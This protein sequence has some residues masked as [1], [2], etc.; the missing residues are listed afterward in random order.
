MPM[1]WAALKKIL[2]HDLLP[3]FFC[4]YIFLIWHSKC[5]KKCCEPCSDCMVNRLN[6][7]FFLIYSTFRKFRTSCGLSIS[8]HVKSRFWNLLYYGNQNFQ[9]DIHQIRY[10][11]S[12]MATIRAWFFF[13]NCRILSTTGNSTI[14][15]IFSRSYHVALWRRVYFCISFF[16]P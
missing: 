15:R 8:L 13:I 6:D 1:G 9:S 4:L 5:N 12:Q 2:E 16:R 7:V 14:F 11:S 10:L 3:P